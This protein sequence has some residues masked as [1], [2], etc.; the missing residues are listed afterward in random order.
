MATQTKLQI[1]D[2]DAHVLETEHSWD[3]LEPSE[4]KF[5]PQ[6]LYSPNDPTR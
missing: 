3:F 4:E 2:A 6:L 1:I 5:R